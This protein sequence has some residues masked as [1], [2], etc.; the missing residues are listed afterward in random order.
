METSFPF[1]SVLGIWLLFVLL[2]ILNG[3]IRVVLIIPIV[4]AYAGQVIRS[5]I[6]SAVIFLVTWYFVKKKNITSKKLTS[7]IGLAWFILTVAFEFVFG[8]FVMGH[9]WKTLIH[10]YNILEGRVWL[11]V[12]AAT[13]FA[14]LVCSSLIKTKIRL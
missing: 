5:I 12:L 8:H 3:T 4:G 10:D 13:L 6:L 2:A 7:Q 1:K 14:P 11:L 9:P